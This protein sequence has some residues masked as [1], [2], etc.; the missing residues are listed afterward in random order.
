MKIP[1]VF[2]AIIVCSLISG[3]AGTKNTVEGPQI[4]ALSTQ[5]LSSSFKRQGVKIEWECSWGT[6]WSD[7]LCVKG[8]F[9]AIE[10]TGYATSNGNSENNREDAFRVAELQAKA[11][12]RRF[13]SEDVSSNTVVTTLTKNIEKANDRIK[14]RIKNAEEVALSD[15]DALKESN[16]AVRENSNDIARTVSDTIRTQAQGILRGVY[17]KD[18][19]IVDRQ[20]A[21]VTIRWDR[22]SDRAQQAMRRKFGG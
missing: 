13:L 1:L 4:E 15:E 16:W 8:D 11:K 19:Q 2:T 22:D 21:K 3:C 5:K 7:A 10:V 9:K 12:L 20:T 14:N 18:E 6:G 17:I